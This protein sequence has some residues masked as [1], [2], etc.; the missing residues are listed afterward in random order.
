MKDSD[1]KYGVFTQ[2]SEEVSLDGSTCIQVWTA[3]DFTIDADGWYGIAVKRV[4]EGSFDFSTDS[5]NV[6]DYVELVTE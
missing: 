1:Y 2:T 5:I 4:D 3:E 6:S